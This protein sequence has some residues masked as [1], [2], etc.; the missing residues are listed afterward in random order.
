MEEK[1]VLAE[2]APRVFIFVPMEVV[3]NNLSNEA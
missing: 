1:K 3:L 2:R